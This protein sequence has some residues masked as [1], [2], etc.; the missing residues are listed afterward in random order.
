MTIKNMSIQLDHLYSLLAP[1]PPTKAMLIMCFFQCYSP[2]S[3]RYISVFS[4]IKLKLYKI[5]LVSPNVMT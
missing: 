4:K 2:G 5:L 3:Y 1:V